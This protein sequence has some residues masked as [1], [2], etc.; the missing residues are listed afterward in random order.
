MSKRL[1]P[2]DRA[3]VDMLLD[4]HISSQDGGITPPPAATPYFRHRLQ[5]VEKWL[6]LLDSWQPAGPSDDLTAR[7]LR[8]IQENQALRSAV[9][10]TQPTSHQHRPIL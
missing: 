5:A 3:A 8:R 10:H 7:T 4:Q 9:S 2:G 6:S 1:N